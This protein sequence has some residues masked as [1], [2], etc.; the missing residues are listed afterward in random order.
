M[1]KTPQ[2]VHVHLARLYDLQP[3]PA[4]F[5]RLAEEIGRRRQEAEQTRADAE[6]DRHPVP[7][8]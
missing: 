5:L 7:H 6:F 2:A 4:E 3:V 1:C 8:G